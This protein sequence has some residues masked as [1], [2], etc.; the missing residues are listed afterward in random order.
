[1]IKLPPLPGRNNL[2]ILS[3]YKE[4]DFKTWAESEYLPE[5]VQV[6]LPD[7][8]NKKKHGQAKYLDKDVI[9]NH[10][11]LANTIFQ[12]AACL[13][14]YQPLLKYVSLTHVLIPQVYFTPPNMVSTVKR[15]TRYRGMY[16]LAIIEDGFGS[17]VASGA[18]SFPHLF[19]IFYSEKPQWLHQA[20]ILLQ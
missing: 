8:L 16:N 19:H 9:H 4:H 2:K 13:T 11:K 15:L 14:F 5:D 18:A 12:N 3:V 7:R 17:K 6:I 10:H 1:M 20:L